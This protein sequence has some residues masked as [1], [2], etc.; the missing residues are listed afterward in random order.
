VLVRELVAVLVAQR[1]GRGVEARDLGA[2]AEIHAVVGVPARVGQGEIG[3]VHV[4]VGRQVD[5]VVGGSRL[6]AEDDDAVG[7]TEALG[8]GL[9]DE[10]EAHHPVADDGEDRPLRVHAPTSP[11]GRCPAVAAL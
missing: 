8:Q 9:L 3:L 4:E 10:P 11:E 7:G 2:E 1:P 5:A 6:L